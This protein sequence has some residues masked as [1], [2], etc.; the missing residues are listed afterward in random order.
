MNGEKVA[1]CLKD[2]ETE[3]DIDIP[4]SLQ[5][6]EM[7]EKPPDLLNSFKGVF[8]LKDEESD[9]EIDSKDCRERRRKVVRFQKSP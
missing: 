9:E 6:G 4:D 5:L 7:R 1:S 3:E 8:C 2:G